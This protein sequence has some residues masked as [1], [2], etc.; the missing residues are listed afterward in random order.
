VKCITCHTILGS[1]QD[2]ESNLRLYKSRLAV[3]FGKDGEKEIYPSAIF[4][5]GQLLSL[6]E[7]SISRRV[8]LHAEAQEVGTTK[9]EGLLLWIFNPDIYYS[10]SKRGPTAHRAMKVFY[11]TLDEIDKFLEQNGNTH[12]ELMVPP[13]DLTE[14]AE[15]L[16]DSTEILP[17][18]ARTFQD[19]TVGLVDRWEKNASGTKRMDENPLNKG[20]DEG[21][22]LFKLPAGMQELYL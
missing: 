13:E 7:S 16:R 17:Q 3:S 1:S 22:E 4:L 6:M 20:V 9:H 2:G 14:F 19:W 5:C 12:E 21:F 11:K 10:S 8:V 18:S 15:T